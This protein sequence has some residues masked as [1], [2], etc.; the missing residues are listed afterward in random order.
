MDDRFEPQASSGDLLT[1]SAMQPARV[2]NVLRFASLEFV[3]AAVSFVGYICFGSA[4]RIV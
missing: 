4:M 2:L 1:E 3:R